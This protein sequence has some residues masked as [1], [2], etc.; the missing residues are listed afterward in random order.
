MLYMAE[1]IVLYGI[2]FTIVYNESGHKNMTIVENLF[3]Y[4]VQEKKSIFLKTEMDGHEI[5]LCCHTHIYLSNRIIRIQI[6]S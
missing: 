4:R 5:T 6:T 2:S 1:K 3:F